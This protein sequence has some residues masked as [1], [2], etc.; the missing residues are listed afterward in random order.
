MRTHFVRFLVLL[1]LSMPATALA[2]GQP[3]K[4]TPSKATPAKPKAKTAPA[5]PA[6]TAPKKVKQIDI[7]EG[8]DVIGGL[9]GATGTDITVVGPVVH[10]SL[11]RLRTNFYDHLIRSA[12]RL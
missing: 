1:A 9:D 6:R 7:T 2:Q 12:E 8:D 11:L 3:P 10:S 5:K 4:A